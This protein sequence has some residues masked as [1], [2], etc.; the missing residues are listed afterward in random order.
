MIA[1]YEEGLVMCTAGTYGSDCD[2]L[3]K[4]KHNCAPGFSC[5]K[6]FK[7]CC[8]YCVMVFVTNPYPHGSGCIVKLLCLLSYFL[9]N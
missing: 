8:K 1:R 3:D 4:V 9:T 7:K 5:D 2:P 6:N